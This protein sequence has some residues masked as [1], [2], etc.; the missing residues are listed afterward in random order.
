[1]SCSMRRARASERPRGSKASG[2]AKKMREKLEEMGLEVGDELVLGLKVNKHH[3]DISDHGFP[4]VAADSSYEPVRF[5]C[6]TLSVNEV[7]LVFFVFYYFDACSARCNTVAY[8][9]SS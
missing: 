7:E 5:L 3:R 4:L 9:S 8:S 1:M 6:E 2:E